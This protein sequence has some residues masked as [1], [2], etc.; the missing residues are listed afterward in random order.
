MRALAHGGDRY[1][2]P[3]VRNLKRKRS[4]YFDAE[5]GDIATVAKVDEDRPADIVAMDLATAAVLE[6]VDLAELCV[7]GGEKKRQSSA[8]LVHSLV[9]IPT[10]E[11]W[12]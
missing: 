3:R 4:T 6:K 11:Y 12:C 10:V 5:G 9:T 2:M 8:R 7:A 1:F